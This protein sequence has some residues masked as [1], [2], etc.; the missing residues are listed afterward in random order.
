MKNGQTV[1]KRAN[2]TR[3]S[4]KHDACKSLATCRE[5]VIQSLSKI[6]DDMMEKPA[7]RS[8]SKGK[9]DQINKFEFFFMTI[10]WNTL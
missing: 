9:I 2:G 1:L 3:W 4:S 6:R 7:T 10:F 8:E 5:E